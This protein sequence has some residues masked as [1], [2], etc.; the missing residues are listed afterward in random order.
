M[1]GFRDGDSAGGRT[2]DTLLSGILLSVK[3]A[4]AESDDHLC[5]ARGTSVGFDRDRVTISTGDVLGV[6]RFFRPG[7]KIRA[8]IAVTGKMQNGQ[9]MMVPIADGQ[10]AEGQDYSRCADAERMEA[11]ADAAEDGRSGGRCSQGWCTKIPYSFVLR[12]RVGSSCV[13]SC[14]QH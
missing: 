9:D 2:C 3:D 6:D 1:R 7:T 4:A 10:D 5:L 14:R 8:P 11:D 12:R 13:S